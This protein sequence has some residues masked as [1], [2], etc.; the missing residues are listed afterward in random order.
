MRQLPSGADY[1]I[2][3]V[4]KEARDVANERY[5]SAVAVPT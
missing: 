1:T 2:D 4:V 5:R 3:P